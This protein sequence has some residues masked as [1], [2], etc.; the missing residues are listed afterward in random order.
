MWTSSPHS[1][2]SQSHAEDITVESCDNNPIPPS[3]TPITL[4]CRDLNANLNPRLWQLILDRALKHNRRLLIRDLA[5]GLRVQRG[6]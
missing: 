6:G 5:Q 2:A 4:S 1:K 3:L